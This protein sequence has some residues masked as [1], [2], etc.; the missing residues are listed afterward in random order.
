MT[1]IMLK[2]RWIISMCEIEAV[3]TRH[4]CPSLTTCFRPSSGNHIVRD[5]LLSSFPPSAV[6]WRSVRSGKIN[7]LWFDDED[8]SCLL[9]RTSFEPKNKYHWYLIYIP[10]RTGG[11]HWGNSTD[12]SR[13]NDAKRTLNL[14]AYIRRVLRR[15]LRRASDSKDKSLQGCIEHWNLNHRAHR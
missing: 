11:L 1:E 13:A 14:M 6:R 9:Q 4:H 2:A 5:L 3:T 10:T 7:T 8:V 15:L 12:M